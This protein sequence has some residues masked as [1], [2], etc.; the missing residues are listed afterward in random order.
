MS[1]YRLSVCIPTYNR[2]GF[3]G[4]TLSNILSQSPPDVEI[5]IVDGASTDHTSEVV[6]DIQREH[7]NV[8]YHREP[9]NNGVDGDL[10]RAV[11]LARGEYCWLMSS[12]DHLAVGAI[13][14]VLGE[15][16]E[17]H[18]IYL[19]NIMA[20]TRDLVPV[21][22]L[23][24]F[25]TGTE[26]RAFDCSSSVGFLE[27]LRSARSI[28]ALFSYMPSVIVRRSEWMGVAGKERFFGSC[29]AH[30]H[31]LLA[32][33]RD[34]AGLKYIR[35]ALVLTRF[36]NDSFSAQGFAKRMMI[37]FEGYLHL[38]D[39]FCNNDPALR[40]AFLMV[41]TREHRWYRILRL[42]SSISDSREWEHMREMLRAVGYSTAL[43]TF[44][45]IFG[46]F[47]TMIGLMHRIKRALRPL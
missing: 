13:Q 42:R 39:R 45:G 5:V 16:T 24:W 35:D 22:G 14:R 36:G 38:A 27:Y 17:G 18:V 4:A 25:S 11:D 10:A 37:D 2:A 29:Y 26:D 43:I 31:T 32:L 15:I 1:G 47:R 19:C 8:Q 9:R 40:Q 6:E 12:D 20:C 34:G 23:S 3:I 30:V 46:S 41:M 7:P 44:C 28:G 21:R 33:V